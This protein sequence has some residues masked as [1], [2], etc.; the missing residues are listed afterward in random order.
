MEKGDTISCW[1]TKPNVWHTMLYVGDG[2]VINAVGTDSNA[3]I[4]KQSFH[5]ARSGANK[6]FISTGLVDK[7][8]KERKSVNPLSSVD[9]II[10]KAEADVGRSFNYNILLNNC[11]HQVTRWRYG[12]EFSPQSLL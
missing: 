1:G 5:T 11:E 4:K 3:Q 7:Y 8:G 10:R 9:E 12:K 6:C 2:M